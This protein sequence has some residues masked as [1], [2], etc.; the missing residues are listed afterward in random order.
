MNKH[1]VLILWLCIL[2]LFINCGFQKDSKDDLKAEISIVNGTE[3]IKNPSEPLYGELK[4]ELTEELTIGHKEDDFL[5][6]IAGVIS[7]HLTFN[8]K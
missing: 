4:L 8:G 6:F 2:V 7:C 3:V 1:F 5:S